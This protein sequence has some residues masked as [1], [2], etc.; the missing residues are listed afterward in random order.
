MHGIRYIVWIESNTAADVNG[1]NHKIRRGNVEML[2]VKCRLICIENYVQTKAWN[3]CFTALPKYQLLSN[4]RLTFLWTPADRLG[5]SVEIAWG[6]RLST[7]NVAAQINQNEFDIFVSLIEFIGGWRSVACFVPGENV[8]R[9]RERRNHVPVTFH[10]TY[11]FQLTK[12]PA[13][14]PFA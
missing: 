13:N 9:E 7:T 3:T 5:N 11:G 4:V 6:L 1:E 14:L 2:Y 10:G 8:C 12:S